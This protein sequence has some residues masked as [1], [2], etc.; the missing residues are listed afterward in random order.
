MLNASP[1]RRQPGATGLQS[2]MQAV[3]HAFNAEPGVPV[4][5]LQVTAQKIALSLHNKGQLS[6]TRFS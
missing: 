2:N 3:A 5:A 6:Q 4:T 1:P